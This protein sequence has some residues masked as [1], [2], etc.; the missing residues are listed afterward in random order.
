MGGVL[1]TLKEGNTSCD[2]IAYYAKPICDDYK[3]KPVPFTGYKLMTNRTTNLKFYDNEITVE[4]KTGKN[5]FYLMS[6][7]GLYMNNN[8]IES[9]V[10]LANGKYDGGEVEGGFLMNCKSLDYFEKNFIV[11]A[12]SGNKKAPLVLVGEEGNAEGFCTNSNPTTNVSVIFKASEGGRIGRSTD[13]GGG[14]LYIE[15]IADEGY[16]FDGYY[17]GD[18]RIEPGRF[19]FSANTNVEL[20]FTAE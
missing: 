14:A 15:P 16:R 6:V 12:T 17:V 8:T 20:R 18:T 11:H 7:K 13:E 19:E 9:S 1:H 5:L 10:P 2:A 3:S 4:H